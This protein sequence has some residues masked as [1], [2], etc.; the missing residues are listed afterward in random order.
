MAKFTQA[1]SNTAEKGVALSDNVSL[2]AKIRNQLSLANEGDSVIDDNV[3]NDQEQP[4]TPDG[5]R[6]Y[7]TQ[8]TEAMPYTKGIVMEPEKVT[9]SEAL[10]LESRQRDLE[11]D[12]SLQQLHGTSLGDYSPDDITKIA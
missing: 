4:A 8:L 2:K 9:E 7:N 1:I 12:Q 6:F 10:E 3:I 5:S 11:A